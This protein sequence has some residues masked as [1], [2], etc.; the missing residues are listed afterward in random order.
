[1]R[2][3]LKSYHKESRP[4]MISKRRGLPSDHRLDPGLV[5][6]VID[7]LHSQ[8]YNF[9]PTLDKKKLVANMGL[10]DFH[11]ECAPA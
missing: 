10:A 1:M 8:C 6:E 9:K 4:G 7:L 11:G 2:R 5:K 3:L